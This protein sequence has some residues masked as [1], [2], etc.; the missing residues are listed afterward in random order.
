[1]T[2]VTPNEMVNIASVLERMDLEKAK[3]KNKIRVKFKYAK[4]IKE[5]REGVELFRKNYPAVD[6]SE[7]ESALKLV[8]TEKPDQSI[9]EKL[10]QM[11]SIRRKFKVKLDEAEAF[12]KEVDIASSVAVEATISKIYFEE[13]P[14]DIS[15]GQLS[16]LLPIID[17]D[18]VNEKINETVD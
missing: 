8:N 13:L 15:S 11:E 6:L 17:Q 16:I 3:V 18:S 10:K 5:C 14:E 12:N 9:D 7:Y 2:N 4:I 1:M